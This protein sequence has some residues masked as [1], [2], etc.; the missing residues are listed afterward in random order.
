MIEPRL[1]ELRL[2]ECSRESPCVIWNG[3]VNKRNGYGTSARW[4][5]GKLNITGAHRRSYQHF[6]GPIPPGYVI[7]HLCRV[8]ACVNPYHLEAVTANENLKRGVGVTSTENAKKTH[9]NKGH[10][11]SGENL[12]IVLVKGTTRQKRR[13]RTCSLA[14]AAIHNQRERDAGRPNQAKRQHRLKTDDAYRLAKNARQLAAYYR[15]KA[16]R[17]A[18]ISIHPPADT[19]ST[20]VNVCTLAAPSMVSAPDA[21][22]VTLSTPSMIF[23]S[24]R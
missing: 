18:Q 24:T 23:A 3:P 21:T 9:C 16:E 12:Q 6:I 1:L 4:I 11:L 14:N 22:S 19:N 5:D 13:C 10:P 2:S 15:R 17:M 20:S 7:D 8:R